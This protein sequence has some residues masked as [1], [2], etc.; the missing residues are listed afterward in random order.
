MILTLKT[1]GL[2][3]QHVFL[4]KGI[5]EIDNLSLLQEYTAFAVSG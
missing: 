3:L 4:R 2:L 1:N 5:V